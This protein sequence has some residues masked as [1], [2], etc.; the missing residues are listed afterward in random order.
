METG[1]SVGAYEIW[2]L[3]NVCI[4]IIPA[5][6]TRYPGSF[7]TRPACQCNPAPQERQIRE[8][9]PSDTTKGEKPAIWAHAP[10]ARQRH[11]QGSQSFQ[12]L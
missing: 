4:T 12:T 10:T 7:D 3:R 1:C 11:V 6:S 5:F 2:R 9:L 8:N